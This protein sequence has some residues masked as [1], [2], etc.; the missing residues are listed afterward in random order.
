[1][2]KTRSGGAQQSGTGN[3]LTNPENLI[4]VAKLKYFEKKI[5]TK[6]ALATVAET[7]SALSE[8]T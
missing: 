6:N 1:M 3:S 7:R 4:D 5:A 2:A 8:L